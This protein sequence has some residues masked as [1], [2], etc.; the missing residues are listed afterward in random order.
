MGPDIFNFE[1]SYTNLPGHFFAKQKPQRVSVPQLVICNHSLAKMLD[2]DFSRMDNKKLA[3]LFSG[4][5]LPENIKSFCQAY[6]GHQ[7]GYFTMLGDGR[8]LVKLSLYQCGWR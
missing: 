2:L 5:A 7:F 8:A 6:A 1:N 4:N 3:G